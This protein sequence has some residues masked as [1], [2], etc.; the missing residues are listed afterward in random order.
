[1]AS[2]GL[3]LLH[4]SSTVTGG[5]AGLALL[6]S[7]ALPVPFG[8]IFVAVNLPFLIAAI[9]RKGLDFTLRTLLA[10]AVL[11][12]LTALHTAVVPPLTLPPLYAALLGNVLAG[13]GLLILFRHRASLGGFN[14]VGLIMQERRGIPA[15]YVQL[16]LDLMVL[17]ASLIVLP[18][19]LV[20]VSALGAVVLNVAIALNHRADRYTGW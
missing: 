12:A 16:V 17:L 15:G 2:F 6:L 4:S 1:L 20:A 14:I 11:T 18:L 7:Y 13:V 19:P 5:T 8:A 9:S 3:F 10:I